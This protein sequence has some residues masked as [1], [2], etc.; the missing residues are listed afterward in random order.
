V[1]NFFNIFH[2][3]FQIRRMVKALN[4]D[5]YIAVLILGRDGGTT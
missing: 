3:F 5:I 2:N 4:T 1:T